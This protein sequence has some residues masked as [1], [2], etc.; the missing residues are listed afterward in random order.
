MTWATCVAAKAET[1]QAETRIKDL[2]T[3]PEGWVM[4]DGAS[5]GDF[6]VTL[7][8][9]QIRSHAPTLPADRET[10]TKL[11]EARH[12]SSYATLYQAG[13]FRVLD[14]G[15]YDDWR[16]AVMIPPHLVDGYMAAEVKRRH[17]TRESAAAWLGQYRGCVG[18]EV[19]EWAVAHIG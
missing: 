3:A 10:W 17:I 9:E 5:I 19:Y 14:H 1:Q 6:V 11:G 16:T 12:G 7:G 13:E 15:G 4:V 2:S 8:T 18:S